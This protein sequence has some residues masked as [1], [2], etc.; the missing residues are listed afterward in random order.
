MCRDLG[1]TCSWHRDSQ[2]HGP[3]TGCLMDLCRGMRV[4]AWLGKG[5]YRLGAAGLKPSEAH[6]VTTQAF[7]R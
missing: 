4:P 7:L 1:K 2:F 6:H 3:E 5:K